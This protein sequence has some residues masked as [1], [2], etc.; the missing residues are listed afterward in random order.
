MPQTASIEQ[1]IQ[2]ASKAVGKAWPLYAFVTSNPLA[3]FEDHH[4]EEAV[5]QARQL[6]NA[7]GL[8]SPKML[9]QAWKSG[10]IRPDKL[11]AIF[12]QYGIELTPEAHLKSLETRRP[13]NRIR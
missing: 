7:R 6:H 5:R 3:G 11:Q 4:F 13:G 10:Q 2:T 12:E 9:R 8:P 1:T